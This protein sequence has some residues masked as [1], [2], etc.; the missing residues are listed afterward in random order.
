MPVPSKSPC[1]TSLNPVGG[2]E[3]VTVKFH[4]KM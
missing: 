4:R 3:L 2:V 1:A